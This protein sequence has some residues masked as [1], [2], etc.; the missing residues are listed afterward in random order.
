MNRIQAQPTIWIVRASSA[1]RLPLPIRSLTL[2]PYE[3]AGADTLHNI[4]S[5][6]IPGGV[7]ARPAYLCRPGLSRPFDRR[8]LALRMFSGGVGALR[9]QLC[10]RGRPGLLRHS[11]RV[12][13]EPET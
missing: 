13:P 11:T 1:T 12:G 3:P 9:G 2:A 6:P 4:S 8:Q 5:A 10:V 7:L